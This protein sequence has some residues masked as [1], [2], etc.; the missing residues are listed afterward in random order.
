MP[1]NYK[2]LNYMQMH[3]LNYKKKIKRE[4]KI[5]KK[6]YEKEAKNK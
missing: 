5:I 6:N 1:K 4:W 2:N 3:F